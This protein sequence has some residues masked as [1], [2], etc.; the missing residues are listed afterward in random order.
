VDRIICEAASA[1]DEK[2]HRYV[3]V[4]GDIRR[5]MPFG[6]SSPGYLRRTA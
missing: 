5:W 2:K 3:L 6:L 4:N 1:A